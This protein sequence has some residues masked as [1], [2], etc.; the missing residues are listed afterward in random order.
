MKTL[1][2]LTP[3]IRAKIP[4]YKSRCVDDLYSGKEYENFDRGMS[5]RYVEK[6]Y[7]LAG[8]DKPIVIFADN[9][10]EYKRK[11]RM[12]HNP[13]IEAFVS[14][15]YEKKNA[16]TNE[17]DDFD[18]EFESLNEADYEIDNTIPIKSH[19]LF[20][21]STYHRVYLMWY[22]F[23]Q[24][25]FNIDHSNKET[26]NWLYENANNNI[27]RIYTTEHYVLVLRMP[28]F[29]RRNDVGFHSVDGYAIEWEGYGMYYINGRK[30]PAEVFEG[31]INK[32]YTFDEFTKEENEDIKA[33]VITLI[34]EKF[35]ADELMKFL[36]ATIVDE[37]TIDHT[38]GHSEV[39]K[40]WKTK[41]KYEFLSDINGVPDQP[42]AWL[43]LKCPTTGSIYLISTSPHFT[44]AIECCKF[45]RP[46]S[47]PM[48]LK[49]DF[50]NFN[51]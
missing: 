11:F 42:Y 45:H 23:I 35:G 13:E 38:S 19:Y 47:I 3:E 31:V 4:E 40:L 44:D 43:E 6:V 34:E 29:I 16:S 21:C 7:E 15:L 41:E 36:N 2:D 20:L 17:D 9:P 50:N 12:L 30:L 39:V 48:E 32:T 33:S 10:T 51:N 26:L 1:D 14:S 25:E 27:S 49:Y 5:T 24:D 18:I 28:K 8:R 37:Q 22:K 46:Q